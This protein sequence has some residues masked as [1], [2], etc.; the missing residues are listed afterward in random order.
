M[1]VCLERR[2]ERELQS[3][4]LFQVRFVVASCL[5]MDLMPHRSGDR[6]LLG[7]TLREAGCD[8]DPLF[9]SNNGIQMPA[10]G[11]WMDG[12]S[13]ETD[14]AQPTYMRS[15]TRR[16]LG[17]ELG[18]GSACICP[19]AIGPSGVPVAGLGDKRCQPPSCVDHWYRTLPS[20]AHTDFPFAVPIW[21]HRT[22]HGRPEG[23]G[24]L[25][26]NVPTGVVGGSVQ[27]RKIY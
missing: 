18:R 16:W 23:P 9:V 10:E 5:H 8:L 3:T 24:S 7:P 19:T 11:S 26:A 12:A 17:S 14:R 6:V 27:R 20:V 13:P 22:W 1:V 15:H 21:R 4:R 25:P 2:P